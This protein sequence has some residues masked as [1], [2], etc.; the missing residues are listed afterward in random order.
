[1][2]DGPAALG[3][4]KVAMAWK[5]SRHTAWATASRCMC[6]VSSSQ[7]SSWAISGGCFGISGGDPKCWPA[8]RDVYM[9]LPCKEKL[10]PGSDLG[11]SVKH[12]GERRET[13]M[14][15]WKLL[16]ISW[17]KNTTTPEKNTISAW[18]VVLQKED[19][20]P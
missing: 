8:F 14:C 7:T 15:H 12:R 2:L 13:N 16:R 6:V 1:M 19:I 11:R 18:L 17:T 9:T 5:P 20:R 4:T 10:E 3:I